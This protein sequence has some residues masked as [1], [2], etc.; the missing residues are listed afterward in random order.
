MPAVL[1]HFQPARRVIARSAIP[2][3]L[4]ACSLAAGLT[5]PPPGAIEAWRADGSLAKRVAFAR[6]LGGHQPHPALAARMKALAAGAPAPDSLLLP[7]PTGLPSTGTPRIFVALV[8]FP[9]YTRHNTQTL[10]Q[11]KISGDGEEDEQPLESLRRFYQRSSYNLLDIQADVFPWYQAQNNRG[12]Y[13]PATLIK[14]VLQHF[15]GT[16]NFANYDNNGDGVIDYFAILWS[17]PDTGW[18]TRWWAWCDLYA[19]IFASDSFTVDGKR[20]G[21]FS[22]QWEGRP[23]GDEFMVDTLI[24]ETGHGLGLPDL[25]DYDPQVGAGGGVGG[26]DM[27]DANWCDHNAFSKWMLGWLT[28]AVV[29]ETDAPQIRWLRPSSTHADAVMIMPGASTAQPFREFYLVQNRSRR[30]KDT[31][32]FLIPADGLVIWHIDAELNGEGTNF[33]NNN[34]FTPHKLVRLMEADGKEQIETWGAAVDAGDFYTVPNYF[35]DLSTPNSRAYSGV[36]TGVSVLNIAP[37]YQ[38]LVTPPSTFRATFIHSSTNLLGIGEAVENTAL[39][40]ATT[41]DWPWVGQTA[42]SFRGGDAARSGS[43]THSQSSSMS[44]PV[45][46]P[47][48][49]TFYW[50]VSCEPVN[51]RLE[52]YLDSTLLDSFSGERDWE[53]RAFE[54]G[55]GS[56]TLLWKYVKNASVSAGQDRAWVDSVTAGTVS[57]AEALDNGLAEWTPSGAGWFGQKTEHFFGGSSAQAAAVAAGQSAILQTSFTGPGTLTFYWKSECPGAGDSLRLMI[58]GAQSASVTGQADWAEISRSLTSG[59]HT[60]RWELVRSSSSGP[61]GAWVDKVFFGSTSMSDALDNTVLPF[62]TSG[63]FAW[64]R[65]SPVVAWGRDAAQAGPHTGSGARAN[66]ETSVFGP[67][68]LKFTWRVPTD[69]SGCDLECY[70]NDVYKAFAPVSDTLQAA[71]LTVPSGFQRVRWTALIYGLSSANAWLDRV[72][73]IPD[74]LTLG[75]ALDAPELAW[76][77]YGPVN[78]RPQNSTYSYG[79]DA[80]ESGSPGDNLTT[81]LEAQVTGGATVYFDWKVSSEENHDYSEFFVN[82][83][84]KQRISGNVDWSRYSW[85]LPPG[86]HTLAWSYMKDASGLGGLDSAWVDHVVRVADPPLASALDTSAFSWGTTGSAIWYGEFRPEATGGSAARSGDIGDSQDSILTTQIQGPGE[87]RFRWKVSSQQT[88]DFLSLRMDGVNALRISGIVDW[89]DALAYVQPGAHLVQW[90]FEKDSMFTDYEDSGWVDRVEFTPG[91]VPTLTPTPTPLPNI[92]LSEATDCPYLVW[93][94]AGHGPWFGQ[95]NVTHDGVDA[96]QSYP[97]SHNQYSR[98][99]TTATGPDTLRFS[100]RTSSEPVNDW[101]MFLLD[102]VEQTRISGETDWQMYEIQIPAGDHALNWF[103]HKNDSVSQGLDCA[104]LDEVRLLSQTSANGL[105]FR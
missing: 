40:W 89:S 93:D 1:A 23:V 59:A 11:S 99:F 41:G 33:Y 55:E 42:V 63:D 91:A 88:N 32:D 62:V 39:P 86:V 102:G 18:G 27:M 72:E 76:Q 8:D 13:T 46:G 75:E 34:S 47:G 58:D 92:P 7:Y 51:D 50:K 68:T 85:H 24:H 57:L 37:Y 35:S 53:Q 65:R 6:S 4:F 66:L 105:L 19:E 31:N 67:G 49:V 52:F 17:G 22:W 64:T 38:F 2:L 10:I 5:P 44:A 73:Y 36:R 80:A 83:Y 98:I 79:F 30:T 101:F 3:V 97:I 81:W 9:N 21:V 96:A 26:F 90:V 28:P 70:F 82:G 69:S 25:Y 45:T 94:T 60:V 100:W 84:M 15:D 74:S 87:L 43:I 56:H 78:W 77:S 14:E 61:C 54:Y 95:A 103:F 20:L 29:A 16:V 71:T 104:W 48:S 12:T